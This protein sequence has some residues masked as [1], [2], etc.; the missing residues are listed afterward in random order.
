M[1]SFLGFLFPFE[2]P[3]KGF[4]EIGLAFGAA[5]LLI[6]STEKELE[7]KFGEN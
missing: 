2:E 1:T 6:S 5:F 7:T 4:V 3:I